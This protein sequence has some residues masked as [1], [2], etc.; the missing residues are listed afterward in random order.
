LRAVAQ[1]VASAHKRAGEVVARY[2]GEE[3]AVI[4]PGASAYGIE[5][6]AESVRLRVL[7]LKVPH[8]GSTVAPFVTVSVGVACAEPEGDLFPAD[9]VAAA[10]RALY[11]AKQ[12]GRNRVQVTCEIPGAVPR[13]MGAGV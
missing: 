10:D 13:P 1:A 6:L 9:L 12:Q 5:A 11:L 7:D 2:G 8:R 4:L 3:L